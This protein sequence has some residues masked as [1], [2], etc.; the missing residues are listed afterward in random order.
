MDARDAGRR[1]IFTA[2]LFVI[3]P[4]LMHGCVLN[5]ALSGDESALS[6]LHAAHWVLPMLGLLTVAAAVAGTHGAVLLP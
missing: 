6:L 3:E 1:L 2:L 5:Q 4:F